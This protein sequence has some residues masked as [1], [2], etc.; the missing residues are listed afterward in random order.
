MK[1]LR[2]RW[3]AFSTSVLLPV[4]G[5]TSCSATNSASSSGVRGGSTAG[6]GSTSAG[7]TAGTANGSGTAASANIDVSNIT[8]GGSSAS[9]DAGCTHIEVNF[10]PKIPTVFVLV[11]R[12]DSMFV[13]NSTTQVASWAPLKAG[14]LNVITQLQ[15]Q[16]RFGFGAFS[17]QQGG[18]C[19]I[20]DSI[21]PALDNAQAITNVY[22]PLVKLTGV[23]GETPVTQVLPLVQALLTKDAN[24]GG[25]YILF[26]TD[27]EPDF[28]DDGD[29]QCPVDALVGRVQGLAAAGI[30]TI[31]FGLKSEQSAIS[32]V[33]LQAVANAGAD[34]PVAT[35][36]AGN[37]PQNVCTSCASRAGWMAEWAAL[38]SA[39]SCATPGKQVLGNYAPTGGAAIVYHPD[40]T[41][42]AAL[43]KQISSAISGVKSCIFDL[44][45]QVSVNL[46]LLDQASV[47]VGGHPVPLSKDNG[48]RMN[49]DTQLELVGDACVSWHKPENTKIDFTFPCDIIV[50]K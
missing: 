11:D 6:G 5:A 28:C 12:S 21:A 1:Y 42:Q 20:F 10:V 33:A 34:Q 50:P 45:G 35:P 49:S 7:A 24:D 3:L 37:Q 15:G 13:P 8:V 48:W 9:P 32:D 29:A 23:K 27:G 40:P 18:T 17:G 25:K 14:V 43:T 38:G 39:A 41:D 46:A 22:Q 36:F 31:V 44:G 26:V 19:P 4:L 16:I 47:A 30:H 2:A